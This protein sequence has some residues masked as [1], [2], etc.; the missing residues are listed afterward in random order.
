MS[1]GEIYSASG[2]NEP[3][4]PYSPCGIACGIVFLCLEQAEL[5]LEW[6]SY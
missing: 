1:K 2:T 6:G 5:S 3:Q 4:S